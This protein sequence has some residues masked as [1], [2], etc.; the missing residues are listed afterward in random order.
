MRF[1]FKSTQIIG[2]RLK[3]KRQSFEIER[4]DRQRAA[5]LQQSSFSKI[6]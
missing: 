4:E 3:A 6:D 1:P 2:A 5:A